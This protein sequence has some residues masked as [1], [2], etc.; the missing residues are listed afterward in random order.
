[1]RINE[2]VVGSAADVAVALCAAHVTQ[3]DLAS[4]LIN[5]LNRIAVLEALCGRADASAQGDECS[6]ADTAQGVRME[7]Y[8]SLAGADNALRYAL[9]LMNARTP[10]DSGG[11]I[12]GSDSVEAVMLIRG[13]RAVLVR[14]MDAL[15]RR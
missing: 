8:L 2:L 1:M 5:A 14:H 15:R 3:E 13:A 7:L 12:S 10:E 4:A 9:M 6:L 11:A